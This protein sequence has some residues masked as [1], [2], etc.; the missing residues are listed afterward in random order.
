MSSDNTHRPYVKAATFT[1]E[2]T[3]EEMRQLYSNWSRTYDKVSLNYY[4]HIT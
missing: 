3:I 4:N 2:T 1:A